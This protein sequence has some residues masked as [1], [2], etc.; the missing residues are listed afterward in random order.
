MTREGRASIITQ[1]IDNLYREAK[2]DE[3]RLVEF[4]GN[5]YHCHCLKC[6][7]TIPWQD[8]LKSPVH[9]ADGGQIRPDLVLY[10]EGMTTSNVMRAMQ[11]MQAS[12]LVVIVG[13]AMAVSPFNMLDQYKRPDVPVIVINEQ[14]IAQIPFVDHF[15]MLQMDAVKFFKELQA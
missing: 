4:H 11:M 6:G 8:Y 2:A 3:N 14:K 10:G 15:T 9:K 1:N 5:I 7:K 12:D 13:T